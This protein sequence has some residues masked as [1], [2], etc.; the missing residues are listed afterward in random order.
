MREIPWKLNRPKKSK[1]ENFS[2]RGLST[3]H[4]ISRSTFSMILKK[5]YLEGVFEFFHPDPQLDQN[6]NPQGIFPDNF[7]FV[8]K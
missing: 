7:S 3:R 6:I 8:Y 5:P 4:V 2:Q 1:M